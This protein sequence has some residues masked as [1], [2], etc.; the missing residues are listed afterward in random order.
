ME[1]GFWLDQFLCSRYLP[2]G[3]YFH[4]V[5]LAYNLVQAL[6]LLKLEYGRWYMTVKMVGYHLFH[7]AG[8]VVS[9]ARQLFL[10]LFHRYPPYELFHR[11]LWSP[12]T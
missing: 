10:K 3:A 1:V 4:V 9:H 2:S 8:L 12:S 5:L 6:E 7:V 11:I